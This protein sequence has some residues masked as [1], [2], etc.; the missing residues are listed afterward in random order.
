MLTKVDQYISE[1]GIELEKAIR[2]MASMTG[3][4]NGFVCK[5]KGETKLYYRVESNKPRFEKKQR[6]SRNEISDVF[7]AGGAKQY[8]KSACFFC[9][10]EGHIASSCSLKKEFME[11]KKRSTGLENVVGTFIELHKTDHKECQYASC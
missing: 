2:Y 9:E 8:P 3:N 7:S 10:D 6:K 1:Y 11:E 5:P 4:G